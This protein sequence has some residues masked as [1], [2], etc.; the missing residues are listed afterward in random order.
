MSN[1]E[2]VRRSEE[3]RKAMGQRQI[4]VWVPD[5][6]EEIQQVKDLARALVERLKGA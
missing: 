4:V 3:K 5:S 1:S 6:S 2:A